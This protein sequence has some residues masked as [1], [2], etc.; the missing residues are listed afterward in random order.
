[1]SYRAIFI[2]LLCTRFTNHISMPHR[3]HLLPI[4]SLFAFII[5]RFLLSLDGRAKSQQ[6]A[7]Y[8][9]VW[10]V[11]GQSEAKLRVIHDEPERQ[12][13]G[14]LNLIFF[15]L[16]VRLLNIGS[17]ANNFAPIISLSLSLSLSPGIGR[18]PALRHVSG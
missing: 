17:I 16:F 8:Q 9:H 14:N 6:P 11:T 18:A 1:M 5:W 2:T 15:C 4:P 10:R 13:A 12:R 7:Y 3:F